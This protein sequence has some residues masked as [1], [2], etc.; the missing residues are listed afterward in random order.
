MHES[1]AKTAESAVAF[2]RELDALRRDASA[3]G[4]TINATEERLVAIRDTLMRSTVTGTELDDRVRA[5]IDRLAGL[6]LSLAGDEERRRHGD[7]GPI[8]INRRLDVAHTGNS[9]WTGGPT[10]TQRMSVEIARDGLSELASK[11]DQLVGEDLP[12]LE[13]KLDAAGVPWTPGR[14][15]G[16]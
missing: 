14:S 7:P 13:E 6:K 16:R 1:A 11:L 2:L 10:T 4:A 3:A 5:L 9:S 8:S 12:A 15:I